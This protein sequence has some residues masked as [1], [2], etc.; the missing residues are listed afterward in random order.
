MK[1]LIFILFALFILSCSSNTD[2]N[3]DNENK[4]NTKLTVYDITPKSSSLLGGQEVNIIGTGFSS[5]CSVYFDDQKAEIINSN[6]KNLKIKTPK[7]TKGGYTDVK[8]SCGDN[9]EIIKNKFKYYGLPIHY[10][11]LLSKKVL[12]TIFKKYNKIEVLDL[13]NDKL[14]DLLLYSN[15]NI[16][17]LVQNEFGIF[18]YENAIPFEHSG[19]INKIV[20]KDLNNDGIDE[21]IV[22]GENSQIY[23]LN[24]NEYTPSDI[25]CDGNDFSDIKIID[26]DN[27][28]DMDIILVSGNEEKYIFIL[29]N[30]EN[31]SFEDK[32]TD[33]IPLNHFK[34]GGIAFGD[35]NNDNTPDIFVAGNKDKHYLL[36]NDGTGAFREANSNLNVNE[37]IYNFNK[38]II[39]DINNDGLPDIYLSSETKDKI[40]LQKKDNT[41][42]D[43]T[44]GSLNSLNK[45]SISVMISDI[46]NDKC[47]DIF[48]IYEDGDF[49]LWHNDCENHYF[50]YSSKI[51]LK[52]NNLKDG[53]FEDI[54]ND[55]LNDLILIKNDFNLLSWQENIYETFEDSDSDGIDNRYDNCSEIKNTDQKNS[56]SFH[57][58][59]ETNEECLEKYNCSLVRNINQKGYLFCMNKEYSWWQADYFCKNTGGRLAEIDSEELNAFLMANITKDSFIGFTD[60]SDENNFVWTSGLNSDYRN[61]DEHQPDNYH[62]NENCASLRVNG[63][64]N[65]LNCGS[66][67]AFICEDS[68]K[69]TENTGDAC[70]ECAYNA[71]K[72]N[73]NSCGCNNETNTNYGICD[74][75]SCKT[76]YDSGIHKDGVYIINPNE[77]DSSE[78]FPVYCDMTTDGGG[79]TVIAVSHSEETTKPFDQN[80]D[81]IVNK[82]IGYIADI[83]SNYFISMKHY[84]GLANSNNKVEYVWYAKS[85]KPEDLWQKTLEYK[86]HYLED[87]NFYT[88]QGEEVWALDQF[89]YYTGEKLT[90]KDKDNDEH[91]TKNCAVNYSSF[92]W[93]KKCHAA[94][95]WTTTEE[96]NE[97]GGTA[98]TNG[99]SS[100]A[101]DAAGTYNAWYKLKIMIR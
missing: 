95:Y 3:N 68:I 61:W 77:N 2:T 78:H 39:K 25:P 64:W 56:D 88:W 69:K 10:Q 63:K 74:N 100:N 57:F 46:D 94:H 54:N 99:Y 93:Y 65:D 58:S 60:A 84:I 92:G 51:L 23:T 49:T 80:W 79:W 44:K 37:L 35:L 50:D 17:T 85:G 96:K 1:S 76:I 52:N 22:L 36:L 83:N 19:K 59:C 53:V 45:N 73:K 12:D 101:P 26:I 86:N 4:N 29:I 71:N 91:E 81:T 97:R 11:E 27:D 6:K 14:K 13:N 21:W 8:V 7:L 31:N 24:E 98:V 55:G 41:F 20:V 16:D 43:K 34:T 5:V 62:E 66:K 9:Y 47:L 72:E 18:S 67:K 33:L 15:K 70:D 75:R 32:T 87:D 40:Y 38:P 30:N 48:I 90:T 82:G 42:V 89:T 28:N